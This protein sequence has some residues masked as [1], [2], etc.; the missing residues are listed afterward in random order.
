MKYN[1]LVE[2]IGGKSLEQIMDAIY[3]G[4]IDTYNSLELPFIEIKT[5]GSKAYA[6]GYFLQYKMIEVMLLAKALNLNAFDQP[7]VEQY[8]INTKKYLQ[9]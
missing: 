6:V 7:S 9:N 2:G 1:G 3:S 8:K 5:K 4:V